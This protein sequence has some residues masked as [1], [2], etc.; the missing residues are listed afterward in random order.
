MSLDELR[1]QNKQLVTEKAL[2]LF[3]ENGIAATKIKD[4]AKAAGVTERSVFRYFPTKTDIVQAAAYHYWWVAQD[5]AFG[6]A[7]S[8]ELTGI[9][10]IRAYLRMYCD[11]FLKYP[12]GARFTVDAEIAFYVA[13]RNDIR[14]PPDPYENSERLLVKAIKKGLTDGTV[15]PGCDPR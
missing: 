11:Y 5:E 10:Q 14:R 7:V 12:G 4:I 2:E 13:G 8:G 6:G 1:E 15:D 9:E 3:I